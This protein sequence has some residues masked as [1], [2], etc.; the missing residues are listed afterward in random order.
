MRGSTKLGWIDWLILVAGVGLTVRVR[1]A[2]DLRS[3]RQVL[4]LCAVASLC[5]CS[6][7]GW[8]VGRWEFDRTQ[9]E[10]HRVQ[11]L[12]GLEGLL[13]EPLMDQMLASS[14]GRVI[15]LTRDELS[16][17]Q[18]GGSGATS[19]YEVV[20]T[21]DAQTVVLRGA[22]GHITTMHHE[23]QFLWHNSEGA[24]TTPIYYRRVGN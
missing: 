5:G 8:W 17:I 10:I 16:S 14:E 9:T 1:E 15:V 6:P 20:E 21:P 3:T 19:E 11:P 4:F 24:I 23:G 12:D 18:A 2:M 13:L 7:A 22:N